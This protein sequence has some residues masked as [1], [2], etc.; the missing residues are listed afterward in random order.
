[1]PVPILVSAKLAVTPPSA[2]T[3]EKELVVSVSPIVRI[4]APVV[5]LVVGFVP[6]VPVAVNLSVVQFR[7]KSFYDEV[8]QALHSCG[9]DPALLELEITEGIA[10][11][12][13]ELTLSVLERLHTLGV[14]LAIDD[15]GIGY[16]SLNYLK[17]FQIE[18]LKIDQSFVRDLGKDP[19]DEAIVTAIIGMAKGLGFKTLAEGVETEEQLA[20]LRQHHC[21]E[22]QG[23]LFSKPLAP[24]EF[25]KLF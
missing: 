3:P 20:F 22:V 17:R 5:V 16:S 1:M 24:E 2:M 9:L 23:F 4:E 6:V 25:L 21:D 19:E 12:N 14:S 7:Q 18:K 13:S 10:M 11:D 15:F 8:F